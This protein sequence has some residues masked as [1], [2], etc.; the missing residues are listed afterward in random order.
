MVGVERFNDRVRFEVRDAR[1]RAGVS[2]EGAGLRA[3]RDGVRIVWREK[4]RLIPAE[5]AK[6][7]RG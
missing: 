2:V 4:T 6:E 7:L 3:G 1:F 5:P